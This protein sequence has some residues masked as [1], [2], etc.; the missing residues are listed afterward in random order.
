MTMPQ[1]SN[2]T[3]RSALGVVFSMVSMLGSPFGCGS[4]PVGSCISTRSPSVGRLLSSLL[5]SPATTIVARGNGYVSSPAQLVLGATAAG[6]VVQGVGKSALIRAILG[7]GS[8]PDGVTDADMAGS[9][10]CN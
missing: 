6:L 3:C 7:C 1:I 5:S 9:I 10:A 4:G 2:A 8:I